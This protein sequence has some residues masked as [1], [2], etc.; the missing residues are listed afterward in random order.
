MR[1]G[2]NLPT[3]PTNFFQNY[4]EERIVFT[5]NFTANEKTTKQKLTNFFL[6]SL[7]LRLRNAER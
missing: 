1:D 7:K 5:V 2:T 3:R 4:K 6:I